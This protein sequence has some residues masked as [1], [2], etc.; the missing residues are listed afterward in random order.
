MQRRARVR[1]H[2]PERIASMKSLLFLAMFSLIGVC[3]STPSASA[4]QPPAVAKIRVEIKNL[5]SNAGQVGCLLFASADG[6]PSK[7]DKAAQR[8]FVPIKDKSAVCEFNGVPPS[9]YAIVSMHDENANG[10][11]D[12]NFV[13]APTEGAGASRDARPGFMR[14]PRFEDAALRFDAGASTTTITIHY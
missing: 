10:R 5:R 7:P 1:E 3:S 6:F 13:G 12:T 8:L 9:T 4:Q 11:F 2:Q 14:G